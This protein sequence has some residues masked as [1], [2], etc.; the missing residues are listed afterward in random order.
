MNPVH[1]PA[2]ESLDSTDTTMDDSLA[3]LLD[4]QV[5]PEALHNATSDEILFSICVVLLMDEAAAPDRLRR[6]T[7]AR[8]LFAPHSRSRH[9]G[10]LFQAALRDES[11]AGQAVTFMNTER[12]TWSVLLDHVRM[13]NL[14]P[15]G[16]EATVEDVIHWLAQHPNGS[17]A[18][19]EAVRLGLLDQSRSHTPEWLDEAWPHIVQ[20]DLI[21]EAI[22]HA[23]ARNLAMLAERYAALADDEDI[24]GLFRKGANLGRVAQ[25]VF[26]R[27]L[28]A[29]GLLVELVKQSKTTLDPEDLCKAL[30]TSELEEIQKL[31]LQSGYFEG[32]VHRELHRRAQTRK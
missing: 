3:A 20:L 31:V 28:K 4:E 18:L 25:G 11:T 15:N 23:N 9:L 14:T 32:C 2:G 7:T 6:R 16:A 29:A 10:A 26:F 1:S 8:S 5:T 27:R 12:A 21:R 19:H 22:E 17:G 24:L 13:H 30:E